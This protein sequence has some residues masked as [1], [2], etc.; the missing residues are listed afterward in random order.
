MPISPGM[1]IVSTM[2][3]WL[4][5]DWLFA[6]IAEIGLFDVEDVDATGGT[7]LDVGLGVA[8]FVPLRDAAALGSR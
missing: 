7:G 3:G 6:A 5:S 2:V 1:L 8:L 4:G